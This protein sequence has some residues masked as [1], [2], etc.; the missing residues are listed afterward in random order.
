MPR[1]NIQTIVSRVQQSRNIK[2]YV[3]EFRVPSGA[4]SSKII[5]D[6]L[7]HVVGKENV[8]GF[9]LTGGVGR[10]VVN[11]LGVQQL[12]RSAKQR[13]VTKRARVDMIV[14]GRQD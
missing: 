6:R 4:A 14:A 3:F 13:R 8:R 7:V 5:R 1:A 12:Q 2:E 9:T 11:R 10:L